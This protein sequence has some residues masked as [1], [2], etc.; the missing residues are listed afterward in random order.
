M[1][2]NPEEDNEEDEEAESKADGDVQAK[3]RNPTGKA[4]KWR[5]SVDLAKYVKKSGYE[6]AAVDVTL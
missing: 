5:G 1:R 2:N 4:G 3:S 6:R